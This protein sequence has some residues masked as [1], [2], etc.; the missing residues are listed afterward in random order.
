MVKRDNSYLLGNKFA[1]G[2]GPNQ[3]SFKKGQSPWNKGKKG[4]HFSPATQFQKGIIPFNKLPDWTI[5]VRTGKNGSK[6]QWI[7][8]PE[9][10]WIEYGKWLWIKTFGRLLPG[11]IVHH[12]NG[13]SL[14]DTLSNL[15]AL[16]R[17]DHPVFHNRWGVHFLTESQ[18]DFYMSRYPK[19]YRP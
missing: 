14:E 19:A 9:G 13:N 3:T 12:R 5:T 6:R 10:G 18:Y 2:S 15:I 8:D 11:D 7:K 17:T 1:E 16:P 4:F